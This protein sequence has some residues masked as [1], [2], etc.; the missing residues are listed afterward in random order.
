LSVSACRVA[1]NDF[2]VIS[3]VANPLPMS[4]HDND[5]DSRVS[6]KTE[7]ERYDGKDGSQ[8]L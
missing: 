3:Y 4:P 8:I 5:D 2:V 7:T 6:P 1:S